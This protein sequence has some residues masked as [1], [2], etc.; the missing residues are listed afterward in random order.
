MGKKL[1]NQHVVW[2][3]ALWTRIKSLIDGE[4]DHLLKVN[5]SKRPWHMPIIAAL[6]IRACPY[7]KNGDKNEINRRQTRKIAQVIS[8]YWP[9][10]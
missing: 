6:A 1:R 4:L 9:A 2:R 3:T 8:R 10:I 7:F 5:R